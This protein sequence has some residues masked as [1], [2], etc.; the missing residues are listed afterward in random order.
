MWVQVVLAVHEAADESRHHLLEQIPPPLVGGTD[1]VVEPHLLEMDIAAQGGEDV[2]ED[3]RPGA[4]LEF[5]DVAD[6][7]D[8]A[9]IT[10]DC[11][12]MPVEAAEIG[13]P[14]GIASVTVRLEDHVNA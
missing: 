5:F 9:V 6:P 8:R 2:V 10:L 7:L 1:Q 13:G 3:R 14:E 11:P 4:Y 12:R